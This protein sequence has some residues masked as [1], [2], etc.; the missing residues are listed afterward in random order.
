M[1][2]LE[3]RIRAAFAENRYPGDDRLTVGGSTDES[4][5]VLKGKTWQEIPVREFMSGDTP[6]PDLTLEAFHYYMPALLIASLHECADVA[7][8]LT[9]Y[10]T[11]SKCAAVSPEHGKECLERLSVFDAEQRE[12]IADVFRVFVQRGWEDEAGVSEAIGYLGE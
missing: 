5:Q 7:S 11:P 10:L 1:P 6:I 8:A 3:E 12:V 9:F 4:F 2:A